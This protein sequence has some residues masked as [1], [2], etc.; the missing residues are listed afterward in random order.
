[1]SSVQLN[2][3]SSPLHQMAHVNVSAP[4]VKEWEVKNA[5]TTKRAFIELN[6]EQITRRDQIIYRKED[7]QLMPKAG[8]PSEKLPIIKYTIP[9]L[10]ACLQ[11][12]SDLKKHQIFKDEPPYLTG[13]G[14]GQ[15]IDKLSHVDVD[16]S[17]YLEKGMFDLIP[18]AI[19]KLL[20]KKLNKHFGE[21]K[22]R[23]YKTEEEGLKYVTE[24]YLYNESGSGGAFYFLGLGDVDLKFI[25]NPNQLRSLTGSDGFHI[26]ILSKNNKAYC[27]DGTAWIEDEKAFKEAFDNLSY[28][29]LFILKKSRD[30]ISDLALRVSHQMTKGF[31]VDPSTIKELS[32]IAFEQI[33]AKDAAQQTSEEAQKTNNENGKKIK[34]ERPF[35]EKCR[36]F[37]TKHYPE[38]DEGRMFGLLNLLSFLLVESKKSQQNDNDSEVRNK[39]IK[40]IIGAWKAKTSKYD[41]LLDI[42]I[43][44]PSLTSDFLA[45]VK[46]LFFMQW[47]KKDPKLSAYTFSFVHPKKTLHPFLCTSHNQKEHYLWLDGS[48]VD[49]AIDMLSSWKKL[50]GH[51]KR[52][53]GLHEFV[54]SIKA[55]GFD[56]ADLSSEQRM[57]CA[58][59]FIDSFDKP[60]ISETL[61]HQYPDTP[62]RP[63]LF[64]ERMVKEKVDESSVKEATFRYYEMSL[65]ECLQ[66]VNKKDKSIEKFIS[67]LKCSIRQI[68]ESTDHIPTE[69]TLNEI[70]KNIGCIETQ[71]LT[72][73]LVANPLST[74]AVSE[75]LICIIFRISDSLKP[76]QLFLIGQKIVQTAIRCGLFNKKQKEQVIKRIFSVYEGIQFKDV[77]QFLPD[78]YRFLQD[79]KKDISENLNAEA[80]EIDTKIFN[81]LIPIISNLANSND[82][83]LTH[84]C[85]KIAWENL[86][87]HGI[88]ESELKN[89]SLQLIKNGKIL[90]SSQ[91]LKLSS[92]VIEAMLKSNMQIDNAAYELFIDI[93]KL[94]NDIPND[95]DIGL[96]LLIKIENAAPSN[97]TKAK[98]GSVV[99]KR[100]AAVLVSSLKP[101]L[102]KKYFKSF[103]KTYAALKCTQK[104]KD[105]CQR[106]ESISEMN[107]AEDVSLV[108]LKF[109]EAIAPID[110][111]TAYKLTMSPSFKTQMNA[112]D[113][114]KIDMLI[115][116]NQRA[117]E[118]HLKV[119]KFWQ[120]HPP[121]SL[122][123]TDKRWLQKIHDSTALIGDIF[124]TNL[125]GKIEMVSAILKDIIY[126]LSLTKQESEDFK[127][128]CAEGI[129]N[130]FA[131]LTSKLMEDPSETELMEKGQQ[132]YEVLRD[133]K[134]LLQNDYRD[135]F[136]SISQRKIN[137]QEKLDTDFVHEWTSVFLKPFD[138][139]HAEAQNVIKLTLLLSHR[140]SIAPDKT[141]FEN[142]I[143]LC[144]CLMQVPK[145]HFDMVQGKKLTS[146]L[147][148]L[149]SSNR[150]LKKEE[151]ITLAKLTIQMFDLV[152]FNSQSLGV[153]LAIARSEA[154]LC[155]QELIEKVLKI[156]S[157]PE[158]KF[159][160]YAVLKKASTTSD[161][162][163]F[164][165]IKQHILDTQE[166]P[167]LAWFQAESYLFLFEHLSKLIQNASP[168]SI[169]QYV[170]ILQTQWE[171][172][173]T[174][175]KLIPALRQKM[176][177]I[178]VKALL[179]A[180]N[181]K[182]PFAAYKCAMNHLEIATPAIFNMLIDA[183]L[184]QVKGYDHSVMLETFLECAASNP[185]VEPES[186]MKCLMLHMSIRFRLGL[187]DQLSKNLRNF[188]SIIEVIDLKTLPSIKTISDTFMCLLD[189]LTSFILININAEKTQ[190]VA[191]FSIIAVFKQFLAKPM[192]EKQKTEALTLSSIFIWRLLSA[193]ESFLYCMEF[194]N[195][196]II[197]D[198]QKISLHQAIKMMKKKQ[199]EFAIDFFEKDGKSKVYD[200][201][202]DDPSVENVFAIMECAIANRKDSRIFAYTNVAVFHSYML[203]FIEILLSSNL[204]SPDNMSPSDK[205][206]IEKSINRVMNWILRNPV[207]D[208]KYCQTMYFKLMNIV[209]ATDPDFERKLSERWTGPDTPHLRYLAS[210]IPLKYGFSGIGMCSKILD[211]ICRRRS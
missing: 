58:K 8:E 182:D 153:L 41:S 53:N 4:S 154:L 205:N 166:L 106:F 209:S 36:L 201:E 18:K 200:Q 22:N 110:F 149:L 172:S 49:I 150:F 35:S 47:T 162:R 190:P 114:S 177:E 132:L 64:C 142:A 38:N 135:L 61:A 202:L 66:Q 203:V 95:R 17:F 12:D 168:N 127:R 23:P 144:Q 184:I 178:L 194:L 180:K 57:L 68:H 6:A 126:A 111:D 42:M 210:G 109:V 16:I 148:S 103:A 56:V 131:K 99:Y 207:E 120:T 25:L 20:L 73:H 52:N 39:Y 152:N 51:F 128:K 76:N 9:E 93:G 5:S 7:Y 105:T 102:I 62:Q 136:F 147:Q 187:L 65:S 198:D 146:L 196:T 40:Q 86:G 78:A 157:K 163:Y 171:S 60:P 129:S 75:V 14:A 2:N 1:M 31:N 161:V 121:S 79:L 151:H 21:P 34:K 208:T 94:L 70:L 167:A 91:S 124:R 179:K 3:A 192:N 19:G 80:T 140:F 170:E 159:L 96:E 195:V 189:N 63:S 81:S 181:S 169:N 123:V 122:L 112:D 204:A 143:A 69:E 82:L 100:M 165:L 28:R 117:A 108:L 27:V 44:A 145:E 197:G 59:K 139:Q 186:R 46:G 160:F 15:V 116:R 13:S 11:D 104:D 191:L 176:L 43:K 137:D 113:L 67:A 183:P 134:L 158:W 193:T 125:D 50:E 84:E 98:I 37:N 206:I 174:E 55:L 87:Q 24:N 101:A 107:F 97:H 32:E 173:S 33:K 156:C 175:L 83:E 54:E 71:Q 188:E 10:L 74:N 199:K 45:L 211:L 164:N 133:H 185:D 29:Q 115:Q 88:E 26:P 30:K 141:A 72:G 90:K 138:H 118:D 155:H 92:R 85:W 119:Y 77:P 48:P 130:S 89:V